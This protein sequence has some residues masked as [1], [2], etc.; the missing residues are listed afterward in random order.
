MKCDHGAEKE[1]THLV[2]TA[3]SGTVAG[4]GCA[5]LSSLWSCPFVT[6]DPPN[7]AM[8]RA[9]SSAEMDIPVHFRPAHNSAAFFRRM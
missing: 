3:L 7:A 2:G 8:R 1:Y 4:K 5:P 9:Q 6:A